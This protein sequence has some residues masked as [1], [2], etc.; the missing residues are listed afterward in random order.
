M[1]GVYLFIPLPPITVVALGIHRIDFAF[2]HIGPRHQV[3]IDNVLDTVIVNGDRLECLCAIVMRL[4][5]AARD[6]G[7]TAILAS[8][9]ASLCRRR[10]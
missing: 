2:G 8:A 3:A 1:I 9:A 4:V 7:I 6:N 5:R 10:R